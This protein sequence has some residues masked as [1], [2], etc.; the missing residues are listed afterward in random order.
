MPVPVIVIVGVAVVTGVAGLI[1]W[2]G[3]KKTPKTEAGDEK[4]PDDKQPAA[5]KPIPRDVILAV[6]H[7][8]Q[9]HATADEIV[10]AAEKAELAGHA[11]LATALRNEAA[12][13]AAAEE[14]SDEMEK[15]TANHAIA[16]VSPLPDVSE[17]QWTKYVKKSRT[18]RGNAVSDNFKLGAYQLSARE[19]ADAGFMTSAKKVDEEG[20]SVWV[21]EW[22]P[23]KSLEEFLSSPAQQY[24]AL[25][26][27]TKLH[28]GRIA[29]KHA[30]VIGTTIESEK[31]TLSGLLAVARKAGQ[32]GLASWLK[33]AKERSSFKDT[34]ERFKQFNGMF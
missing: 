17:E 7:L 29:E 19:L 32:G 14:F 27:L 25:V 33:S 13:L 15:E 4:Q 8:R 22:A 12:V 34:T 9:H 3:R 16:F 10:A 23:G 24:E 2:F 28:A 11:P 31:V 5:E 26:A 6:A 20:H 30:E 1:S 18:H 21:G